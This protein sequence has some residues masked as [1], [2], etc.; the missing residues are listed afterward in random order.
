MCSDI[1][2]HRIRIDTSLSV[3]KFGCLFHHVNLRDGQPQPM[4]E[5]TPL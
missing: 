5:I 2:D 4:F 3:I 1:A